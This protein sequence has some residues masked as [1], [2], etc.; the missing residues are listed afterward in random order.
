MR[1]LIAGWASFLH[2][3]ATAG[4]V[5]SMQ[6]VAIA[7]ETAGIP[8]DLVWSPGFR[9]GDQ[10]FATTSPRDYTHV[11]FACGPAHGW[12]LEELHHQ[13]ADLVRI[14]VGTSV[15]DAGAPAV[16]GFDHVL[17][18]DGDGLE[19]TTDLAAR[20]GHDHV[21]VVGVVLAPGQPEFGARRRHET[22]HQSLQDWLAR[23]NAA[24]LPLDTRLD[25]DD[26]KLCSTPDQFAG[27]VARTDIVITTRLHGLVFAL[28]EG[29]PALAVDPVAGG[30][31]VT[32]QAR[33]W[34]WPA[35]LDA[36]ELTEPDHAHQV[37]DRWWAWC[38]SEQAQ[39]L[40][41]ARRES[42]RSGSPLLSALVEELDT[43][44]EGAR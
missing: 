19:P 13:F 33:A 41:R 9:P 34:D 20:P 35:I 15:V 32:A 14:A 26:W 37:L 31:K 8:H 12:Q 7:L 42:A 44:T 4:D 3:E 40:A 22:V 43:T 5:R 6:Q 21:P 11:V 23:Q 39:A 27:L 10:C 36:D 28:A 38:C 2:G 24:P 18:R 16:A 29:V 1:V 25:H 17:A 30:G